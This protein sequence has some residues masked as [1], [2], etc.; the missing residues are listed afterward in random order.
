MRYVK[1]F[2]KCEDSA[3]VVFDATP[4]N[5]KYTNRIEKFYNQAQKKEIIF[6]KVV[7]DPVKRYESAW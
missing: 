3:D 5:A 7:C 1:L 4:N 2:P 6:V